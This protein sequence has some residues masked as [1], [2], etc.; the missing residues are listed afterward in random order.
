VY[1]DRTTFL[2]PP[3]PEN[4]V[5]PFLFSCP[6]CA[7]KFQFPDTKQGKEHTCS[8]CGAKF[9]ASAGATAL[10]AD[11]IMEV[12][13]VD[14]PG[15]PQPPAITTQPG[16]R[17]PALPPRAADVAQRPAPPA[18]PR[19]SA[20]NLQPQGGR[21]GFLLIPLLVG[22]AALFLMVGVGV[23]AYMTLQSH[24]DDTQAAAPVGPPPVGPGPVN[25]WQPRPQPKDGAAPRADGGGQ[26]I[27][28]PPDNPL[29]QP[30]DLDET[31]AFLK[32]ANNE[33]RQRTALNALGSQPVVDAKKAE[34]CKALEPLVNNL[35]L[36]NEAARQLGRWA[37]PEST[38]ALL[39][40]MEI[41]KEDL[42][43][44]DAKKEAMRALA[45]FKTPAALPLIVG[46][47]AD[48]FVQNDAVEALQTW[49]PSAE[50]EVAKA[51]F[52]K[53]NGARRLADQLL[54]AYKT[55]P[56]VVIKPAL[57]ALEGP[58]MESRQAAAEWLSKQKVVPEQQAAVAKALD[59]SLQDKDVWLRD[60]S[61]KA[62]AVWA[63][64]DNL[65]TITRLLGEKFGG[66]DR[67]KLVEALGNIKDEKAVVIA[68]TL[69]SD[70]TS[71]LQ[72][73]AMQA[74][75]KQGPI[76]EKTVIGGLKNPA[77][78]VKLKAIGVLAAIGTKEVSVPALV[79]Q[80][81]VEKQA[82]VR[83]NIAQAVAL[84]KERAAAPK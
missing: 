15:S 79:E 41:P 48:F 42:G 1:D 58:I 55:K 25:P 75:Q 51:V 7:K 80:S 35:G 45:K 4:A 30:K 53:D 54:T 37:V 59:V 36:R 22:A 10:P 77:L 65:P 64:V 82:V 24:S 3:D 38:Q 27:F 46:C 74:L 49:G 26:P 43:S 78:N 31:I 21:S 12:M 17:P 71:G 34:V 66:P 2:V 70:P 67:G 52:D 29:R 61:V 72:N 16:A 33:G 76:A 40:V 63:N 50:V 5:M 57:A 6:Q 39:K 62:L 83:T 19:R 81:K 8:K 28:L 69:L 56:E 47:L 13:P 73:Q 18:M 84:I 20:Q 68:F 44:K 14:M 60:H 9:I 32:E 11:D 23:A